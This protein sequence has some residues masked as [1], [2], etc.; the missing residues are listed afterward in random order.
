MIQID[1]RPHKQQV[2]TSQRTLTGVC[3]PAKAPEVGEP[4]Q[5]IALCDTHARAPCQRRGWMHPW[6]WEPARVVA[7]DHSC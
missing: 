6:V 5:Y 7:T 4:E 1:Q 3:A 2:C